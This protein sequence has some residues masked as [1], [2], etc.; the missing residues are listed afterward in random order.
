M[1]TI[2]QLILAS[3][4]EIRNHLLRRAQVP[5][6]SEPPLLDEAQAKL[7]HAPVETLALHLAKAKA[8]S[9]S[10]DM[11]VL[12]LGADQTLIFDGEIFSKPTSLA[13]AASQLKRFRNATHTL[14][15]ALAIAQNGNVIWTHVSEARLTMRNFTDRFIDEY[16]NENGE[17][18]LYSVGGYKLEEAGVQLFDKIDG[19]YFTILGLPLLP[20][21]H[22]LRDRGIMP[23]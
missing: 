13:D 14:Q 15:S 9:L 2:P 20:L 17:T 8:L 3:T 22:F 1:T 16:V 11:D 7:E 12:I 23:L 10:H 5:F 6:E 4:S 18:L 19:D 21:L